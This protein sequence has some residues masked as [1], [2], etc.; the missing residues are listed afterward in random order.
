M[1]NSPEADSETQIQ[2]KPSA[3]KVHF[4]QTTLISVCQ[5]LKWKEYANHGASPLSSNCWEKKR[6]TNI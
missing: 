4:Q 1:V 3:P 2:P 6:A 5:N